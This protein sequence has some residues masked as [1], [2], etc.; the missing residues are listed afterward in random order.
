M[1]ANYQVNTTPQFLVLSEDQ[2]ED[3]YLAALEVLERVGT[4]VFHDEALELLRNAGAV[5]EDGNRAYIPSWLVKAGL[6]ATPERITLTG[7]TGKYKVMLEKDKIYFGTG[8]DTVFIIDPYTDQRRQWTYQDIYHAAKIADA[9]PNIDFHMSHGLTSGV[10]VGTYDRHQFLAMLEGCTKPLVLT[11]VDGEGLADLYAMACA[12][13]GGEE[14]FARDPLFVIYIEP[15]SPLNNS[16]EALQKLLFSAEK[17]IPAI[18]T[19][20]P[21]AGATGPATM[22][23]L[24]VQDLAECLVGIVIAQLKKKGTPIIIGGVQSI[25]DMSTTIL[26]YG[27]PELSLLSAASTDIAKWL[28]LPMFSTAGCGDAKTL[29]QQAAIEATLSIA[30]AA[31]SG[32]NLIHDVGYLE[33]GMVGS[34]DM[35]VMSDEIIGMVKR[36]MRGIT[37]DEDTLALDVIAR[38]GPG[39]HYLADK[40][41]FTH[42][43]SEF[44]FPKLIDRRRFEEW[45][46][47][48]GKTLARRVRARVI[49]LI[50]NYQ[51]EPIPPEAHAKLKAI[52]AEADK[53][54][55]SV[56]LELPAKAEQQP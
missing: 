3:I 16:R 38:V 6:A 2:I 4:R 34:D 52:V 22:A 45:Q 47:D 10:P 50:E 43:K 8:S 55:E 42:F 14:A 46:A 7:R 40:H 31:L 5:I 25:M 11:A 37:V 28:R 26:S 15:S 30:M 32:A 33:S 29:D 35:L 54:H 44:W 17:G 49:D 27:A 39:G 12:A 48:G 23:G 1:R 51:P 41:T 20:C 19:P 53:R 21:I 9:L 13:V 18:Y 36:I 56:K 24:L